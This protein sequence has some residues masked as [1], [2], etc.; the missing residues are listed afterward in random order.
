M[1]LGRRRALRG[2]TDPESAAWPLLLDARFAVGASEL[3]LGLDDRLTTSRNTEAWLGP[4]P[5]CE[6]S[7]HFPGLS[8]RR[9]EVVPPLRHEQNENKNVFIFLEIVFIVRY[10]FLLSLGGLGAASII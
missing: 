5:G 10:L 3:V 8:S 9:G 2:V 1:L 7:L 4:A 6:G